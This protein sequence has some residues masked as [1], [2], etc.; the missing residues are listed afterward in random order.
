MA[1]FV[2]GKVNF[3]YAQ[4]TYL[5]FFFTPDKY[6]DEVN[7]HKV[8]HMKDKKYTPISCDLYDELEILA[9]R[10]QKSEIVY[11]VDGAEGYW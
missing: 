5:H 11:S 4:S 8:Q 6:G 7:L 1:F 3:G 10:Q 2:F 9:M